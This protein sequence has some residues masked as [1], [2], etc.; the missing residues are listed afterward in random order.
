MIDKKLETDTK[1]IKE[2]NFAVGVSGGSDSLCLALLSKIYSFEFNSKV[3]VELFGCSYFIN[4]D[5]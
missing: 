4:S 5:C 2:E 1:K 3:L